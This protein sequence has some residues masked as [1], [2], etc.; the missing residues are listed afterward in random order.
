MG[1]K[2]IKLALEANGFKDFAEEGEG[3]RTFAIFSG[4]VS[5]FNR[6]KILETY[7][8]I[9]NKH[10][11]R[12]SLILFTATGAEGIDTKRTRHIHILNPHWNYS[13]ISQVIARGVRNHSHIDLPPAER[14]VTAYVYLSTTK[15]EQSTDMYLWERALEN[16]KT[17]DLFLNV[18]KASSV[19][20]TF[21]KGKDCKICFPDNKLLFI[22]DFRKDMVEPSNC[23]PFEEEELQ[24]DLIEITHNG[25]K[26]KFAYIFEKSKRKK[27]LHLFE[28]DP[29]LNGYKEIYKSH[30]LYLE[31]YDEIKKKDNVQIF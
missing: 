15:K 28:F 23:K 9:G 2:F 21:Y 27:E 5:I 18:V 24:P 10:G 13:R 22:P 6:N 8:D 7:N 30:P 14:N 29:I 20:C 26:R 4:E 11:D 17:N 1:I 25:K 31:L 3:K 16:K 12:L 19:D